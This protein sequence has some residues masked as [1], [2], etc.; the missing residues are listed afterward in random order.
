MSNHEEKDWQERLSERLNTN[1][2]FVVMN[3]DT[4]EEVNTY[5][6]TIRKLLTIG[7]LAAVI[8]ASLTALFFVF[9]PLKTYL[10]SI[11]D[12]TG[13]RTAR[14]EGQIED[15]QA[16]L[17]AQQIR[18]DNI[19]KVLTKQ[20]DTLGSGHNSSEAYSPTLKEVTRIPEDEA[21]RQELEGAPS[22]PPVI[23]DVNLPPSE[24][25]LR[26]RFFTPPVTGAFSKVFNPI[27]KHY[28]VDVIAP[29]NT[30]I[31]AT[32]DGY[33]ISADWNLKTGNTICVQHKGDV[34]TFYK[35]NSALLKKVG[36]NVK[37]GEAIAIIGDTGD[38]STGPHLHFEVWHKGVPIDPGDYVNFN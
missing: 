6:S 28:G 4:F 25:P 33:V 7:L 36:D 21:L 18:Q 11:I 30:A 34:V 3:D 8:V 14:L 23:T 10:S 15:L 16:E 31:K 12:N 38:H 5:R 20:V 29:K 27:E 24:I 37:A 26:Q 2:R 32:L 1:Y 9:T 35:H 17:R 19:R 22:E 13:R